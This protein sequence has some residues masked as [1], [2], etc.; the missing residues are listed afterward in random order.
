MRFLLF[1]LLLSIGSALLVLPAAAAP[2]AH[3]RLTTLAQAMVSTSARR[4]PM[5]ATDLGIP[6]HDG[7]LA[8]PTAA[9]LAEDLRMDRRWQAQ[10]RAI[11]PNGGVGLALVDRDDAKLLQA[12]L[13]AQIR[14]LTVYRTAQ[15]EYSGPARAV[16]GSIFTLFENLPIA[17]E[18]GA[19]PATV[20]TAW[21]AIVSRLTKA[22]AY[23]VAGQKLVTHPGHLQGV[24]GNQILAGAGDFFKGPL[25]AT[26]KTQLSG[27]KFAQFTAARDRAI[28]TI[29]ATHAY[30]AAHVNA[31]PENYAM[32]R[33]NYDTL[34]RDEQL[35]PYTASD[36]ERMGADELAHGWAEE[37]WLT[38]LSSQRKTPFGPVTGGGLAPSGAALIGYYHD[39]IADLRNFVQAHD[40]VTVPNWLGEIK[41]VETPSF[42]QPVSPGASMNSPRLFSSSTT[43]YYFIT[44]PKSLEEAA[45][46]LDMNED[47]DR[48]RIWSTAAHEAMPGHFLQ[49]SIAKRHPD[50]IRKIQHSGVFAEGWAFY[51]EEMFVRLGLYGDDLDGRLYTARWERVRGARATVDPK[52]ASGEWTYRQAADFFA[53]QSGFTKSA[54]EAAVAGIALNPGYVISYTVGRLQLENLE[55]QY[56]ARMGAKGSL[57][58]FHDRLLSY[59]TTP[60]AIVAPELLADLNKSAEQVR[61]AANY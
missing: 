52:L 34:L 33:K 46:T 37:A 60:F 61:A 26:A 13:T 18:N 24:T 43:G 48:D 3:D 49:L 10:L 11:A 31:W 5:T 45:R 50:Y 53:Q 44:P 20:S 22:P 35:L 2:S 8:I 56:M 7:E 4:D 54:A 28:A 39:R 51:G 14:E 12:E 58:D 23:I 9:S 30:I 40:V 17:G 38:S 21:D 29:N 16:V 42:L 6:G 57:H 55:A 19:T 32:G 25:T 41:V 47:F 15:K 59:G 27:A 36:V 1:G